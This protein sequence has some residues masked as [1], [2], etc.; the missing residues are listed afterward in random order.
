MNSFGIRFMD[1]K[2]TNLLGEADWKKVA[3]H[4]ES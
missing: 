1:L 3:R 2:I 4:M